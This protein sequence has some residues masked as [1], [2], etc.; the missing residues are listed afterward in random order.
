[1]AQ[2]KLVLIIDDSVTNVFLI[3]SVLIEYGYSVM[4]ALSAAEAL[5]RLNKQKPDLI[6]LDLLMPQISGF[7]FIKQIKQNDN[8]SEIPVIIVSAVTD[9]DSIDE[10]R[11]LGA[12]EYIKKPVVLTVLIDKIESVLL[13]SL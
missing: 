5:V 10:I 4:T 13:N 3:E 9:E 12:I 7:D 2:N 1:M 11:K 6:L 8:F